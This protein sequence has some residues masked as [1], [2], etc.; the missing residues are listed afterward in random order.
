MQKKLLITV[1]ILC[2]VFITGCNLITTYEDTNGENNYSLESINETMILKSNSYVEVGSFTTKN[3]KNI[4]YSVN[5]F[6]G[7][8][9]VETFL[10]NRYTLVMDFIVESGN[11][12]LVLC[13]KTE[14]IHHFSVNEQNQKYYVDSDAK[15]YLKIAG[16]SCKFCLNYC[17]IKNE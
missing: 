7:V 5:K 1:L 17:I 3:N 8:K 15:I 16:E 11:A 13:T 6:D 10:T 2:F 14:I 4:K 12:D 9:T